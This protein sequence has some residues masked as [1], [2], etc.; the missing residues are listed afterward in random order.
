MN[1][2]KSMNNLIIDRSLP[3]NYHD[4]LERSDGPI[5]FLA[6]CIAICYKCFRPG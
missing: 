5:Y 4:S 3:D 1:A 2:D 6:A